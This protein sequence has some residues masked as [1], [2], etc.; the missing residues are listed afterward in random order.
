MTKAQLLAA[1][2]TLP[3]TADV[4][5]DVEELGNEDDGLAIVT[6]CTI[7]RDGDPAFA[8]LQTADVNSPDALT[9][10]PN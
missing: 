1:L 10:T 9:Q 3:D 5:I 6:R 4:F 2:A 7:Y 8:L